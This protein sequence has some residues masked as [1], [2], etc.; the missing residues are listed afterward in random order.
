V[1]EVVVVYIYIHVTLKTK[2]VVE[3]RIFTISQLIYVQVQCVTRE[4]VPSGMSAPSVT[5]VDVAA[6]QSQALMINWTSPRQ[7]NGLLVNYSLIQWLADPRLSPHSVIAN[8]SA[9]TDT[10]VYSFTLNGM[11][12]CTLRTLRYGDCCC[13]DVAV[14]VCLSR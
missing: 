6:T 12:F 8:M 14:C 2:Q 1:S 4:G 9:S 5:T 10:T 13:G 7:P 11:M 3:A